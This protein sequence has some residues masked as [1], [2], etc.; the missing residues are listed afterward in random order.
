MRNQPPLPLKTKILQYSITFS[1]CLV[2]S[3][4]S[5]WI[6]GIFTPWETL[7]EKSNWN[8]NSELTKN[9]FVLTNATFV[10]GVLCVAFGLLVVAANGGAFEM[11]TYGIRRFFSLFKRDPSAVKFKTFYDYHV[12]RSDEPKKSVLYFIIVGAFYIGISMLFLAI[13]N[14]NM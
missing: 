2:L 11:L 9:M 6:M 10:V 12:Y 5:A 13:Y 1:V 7:Q 4:L 3:F 8:F 14:A